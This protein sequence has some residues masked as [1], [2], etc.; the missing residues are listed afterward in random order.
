M[1]QLAIGIAL[2]PAVALVDALFLANDDASIAKRPA[3]R[4]ESSRG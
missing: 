2:M 3:V 1:D 4:C